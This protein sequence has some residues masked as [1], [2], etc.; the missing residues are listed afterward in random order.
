MGIKYKRT[1][2][3]TTPYKP[4]KPI[5]EVKRELG[6]K[7]V[8][9]LASNEN[10]IKPSEK[11]INAVMK[12]AENI[13][14]YPDGGCFYLREALSKE[15]SVPGENI[16]FGNGSDEIIIF[17]IRTFVSPGDEVIISD[18]T[19]LIYRIASEIE[20]AVIKV[21]PSKDLEYDLEAMLDK[22]TPRTKMIFIANPENPTGSYISDVKLRDFIEKLSDEIIIFLDEA[23]YEFAKGGDYP[24][25]LDLIER[26]DRNVIISRTFSKAYG[27]AG[28]R[29]GYALARKDIA[30]VLNKIR[31]PFNI[32][33]IAQA[34]AIA[35]LKDNEY[36]EKSVELV[37]QEKKKIYNE[38]N[39]LG[40]RLFPSRTNFILMDTGRDS[41]KIAGDLLKQGIIVREMSGW[42]FKGYIR[43]N[44]GLQEENDK[45]IEMFRRMIKN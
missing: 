42:G 10:P 4:G 35:A 20:N 45:F 43:V 25:T 36:L 18:P 8:I 5:E 6:I 16:I 44:I 31:E 13:N 1:L 37:K 17:A 3:K 38:L 9:K 2:D 32:N 23:Y 39:S 7:E 21:V 41:V 15:L 30:E 19:F 12:A 11:V 14:R 24:E 27:L 29:I 22:V 34:A 26:E 40:V 28:I 33:S